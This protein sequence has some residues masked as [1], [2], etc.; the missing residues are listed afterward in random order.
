MDRE[1]TPFSGLDGVGGNTFPGL[2]GRGG[3]TP[4]QVRMGVSLS[5]VWTG[6]TPFPGLDGGWVPLPRSG[7]PLPPH[8]DL[9]RGYPHPDL[10]RGTPPP[11]PDLGRG[12]P[13]SGRKGVSPSQRMG[14]PPPPIKK[15]GE[16]PCQPDGGTHRKCGR[17]DAC[18]NITFSVPSNA[19][20]NK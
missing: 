17:T 20:G 15:E 2:N 4:S 1:G 8:P 18:E 19:G 16:P 10:R 7:Y 5:K 9:G 11:H 12:Y 13:S 6:G 3:G 14:I